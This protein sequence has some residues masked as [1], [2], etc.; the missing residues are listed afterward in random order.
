MNVSQVHHFVDFVTT[1]VADG[2]LVPAG[3]K[4]RHDQRPGRTRTAHNQS[5]SHRSS[6]WTVFHSLLFAQSVRRPQK[7]EESCDVGFQVSSTGLQVT[8]VP[9]R[10]DPH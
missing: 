7:A 9:L 4:P 8:L 1:G 2:H 6:S 3:F 5:I 10:M